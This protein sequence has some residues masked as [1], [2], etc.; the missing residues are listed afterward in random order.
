MKVAIS[1]PDP[2]FRSAEQLARQLKK[3]RS[4]LYSEAVAQ[5]VA[6][7]DAKSVTRKLDEVYATQDS[8][9]DSA[10]HRAQLASLDDE[11]W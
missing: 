9:L 3:S 2:V 5:F 7:R 11:A 10:L 4:Q 8:G 1:I 6:A